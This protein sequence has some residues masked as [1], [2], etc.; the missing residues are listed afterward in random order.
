MFNKIKHLKDL[1][2]QANQMQTVLAEKSVT[3]EKKGITLTMDGNQEIKT[4]TINPELSTQEIEEILPGLIK[5][6]LDKVKR[7]MAEVMQSMG[8]L[9]GLGM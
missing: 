1:K 2:S 9:A 4:L 8:G 3:I 6:A 5:E 7:L